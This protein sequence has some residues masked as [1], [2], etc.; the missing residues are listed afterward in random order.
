MMN[1]DENWYSVRGA[2]AVR[3]L[4]ILHA[5]P[6]AKYSVADIAAVP[7]AVA[8]IAS[9]TAM[10]CITVDIDDSRSNLSW[11][12]LWE[13]VATLQQRHVSSR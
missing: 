11:R 13:T 3:R 4:G 6:L 2:D 9:L 12:Q 10:L 8:P 7:D 1:I 5:I